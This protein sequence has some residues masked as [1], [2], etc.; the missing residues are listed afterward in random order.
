MMTLRPVG[1]VRSAVKNRHDMPPGGVAARI[2]ILPRY[3][4]ALEGLRSCSHIWALCF[5]DKADRAV[6]RARPR[7]VSSSL[8]ARGVFA[9]RSPDRPNPVALTCARLISARGLTLTLDRL[10]AVDGTPVADIKPYSPGLD[11]V[12]CAAKPDFSRKY[13]LAADEYLADAFA[14]T[15]KNFCGKVEREE[16]KAAALA[17][18]YARLTGRAPESGAAEIATNLGNAGMDALYALFSLK[19]SSRV[20]RKAQFSSPTIIVKTGKRMA[21]VSLSAGDMRRFKTLL[22]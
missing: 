5:F 10:D 22:S 13:R 4:R 20:V 7:K 17:F 21:R 18:K 3:R 8:A 6:L 14:R 16:L 1:F 15:V 2:E 19:P 9:T 12:P 11:C